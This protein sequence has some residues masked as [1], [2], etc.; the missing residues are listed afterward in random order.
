MGHSMADWDMDGVMD[1][2][3][4]AIHGGNKSVNCDV[5]GCTFSNIGNLFYRNKGNRR[6]ED[7]TD[8]VCCA[9]ALTVCFVLLKSHV[10]SYCRVDIEIH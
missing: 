8:K 5:V 7:L 1:W 3:M 9:P 6:M 2:W 10:T 4:T